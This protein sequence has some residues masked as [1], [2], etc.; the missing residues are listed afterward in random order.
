MSGDDTEPE[1][2]P[3][4]DPFEAELVAYLDG[5]LDEAGARQV[6]ARLARDPAVRARAAE[7]KKS[8]DLLDYLPR[9]EPSPNFTTRTLDKLPVSKS[10]S[11]SGPRASAKPPGA[12]SGSGATVSTSVPIPL[13]DGPPPARRPYPLLRI[14]GLCAAVVVFG[15]LGYLATAAARPLL[16]PARALDPPGAPE[17]DPGVVERLPLYAVADDLNFVQELA[18]PELFGDEPAVS[19]DARL[20]VPPPGPADK[21]NGKPDEALVAAYHALPASRQA[22]I[23]Q[24][25]R[26]LRAKEPRERDRLFRALELYAVWLQRL[27]E[28]ERRGVLGAATPNLRLGVVRDLRERQ[29]LD[30]LPPPL[31]KKV[32]GLAN[33]KEKAE[34]IAQLKDDEAGRRDRWAF[35]RLHADAFAANRSPWPFDTEAGRKEVI[36]FARA[37]LRTDDPRRCRLTPDQ[38]GEY[39]RTLN[40]A[41]RDGAWAW[42]GLT[43][44]ELCKLHPYLP[45]PA[46]PKLHITEPH[47]LPDVY[48]RAVTKKGGGTRLKAN[49]FGRWPEFPLEVLR[50]VPF[51]KAL[52]PNPPPLGP[53]RLA[54]FKEP[55]RTFAAKELFPRL[56]AEEKRDLQRVEGKWPEYPREFVRYATKHDLSVPGVTLPGAPKRWDA[57]Y[58]RRPGP[59]AA[60]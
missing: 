16:F 25:D 8:F 3:A 31:R 38:L 7:L 56:T 57:T 17:P 28:P 40:L 21:P 45:E 22:E 11:G 58:G 35:M 15:A 27:P 59:P 37:T 41:E 24:L 6:E 53:A 46:D 52:G 12:R 60:N 34:L 48:Q 10:P 47:D 54:D 51:A 9:P 33:P 32:E 50:E 44:Y 18:R 49:T 55:V 43:V 5:E 20:R 19:Y 36:E 14:A 30:A 42:Y 26:A 1:D 4:P 29:W 13:D 23:V 2:G 39:R